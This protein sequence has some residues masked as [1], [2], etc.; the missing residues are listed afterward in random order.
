MFDS[1]AVAMVK[2]NFGGWY[3]TIQNPTNDLNSGG[4]PGYPIHAETPA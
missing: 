4:L 2:G 3:A 1:A